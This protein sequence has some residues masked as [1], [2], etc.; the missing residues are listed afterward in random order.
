MYST[1]SLRT[2][3][4]P[5]T[6]LEQPPRRLLWSSPSWQ[7]TVAAAAINVGLAVVVRHVLHTAGYAITGRLPA[8]LPWTLAIN[9][10]FF[11]LIVSFALLGNWQQRLNQVLY[12]A[13]V[14]SALPLF[15]P[16]ALRLL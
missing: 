4:R 7:L 10:S 1:E 9:V 13:V 15:L 2:S 6:P 16:R 14:V 8:L 5:Q 3:P 11:A 12:S